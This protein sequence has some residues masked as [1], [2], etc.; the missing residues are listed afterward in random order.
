MW[1]PKCK[2]EY[3]EGI[4]VCADCGTE[5]VEEEQTEEVTICEISDEKTACELL[6]FLNYSGIKSGRKEEN[7][8]GIG[9]SIIVP[10]ADETAADKVVHGYLLAKEEEKETKEAHAADESDI[11]Q[12]D[13]M[14]EDADDTDESGSPEDGETVSEKENAD[15][16]EDDD[17]L[18][19]EEGEE[20]LLLADEVDEDTVD[21]LYASNKKEYVKKADLYRDTKFSGITFLIFGIIG[22]VYLVLSKTKVIPIHYN[23]VVFCIIAA[24]F[25]AFI[26]AG[27]VS[28]VK[29]KKIK[30]QIPEEEAKIKEI[31]EWLDENISKELVESW[32]D[33]SVSEMENDLVVTAH[34]RSELIKEYPDLEKEYIEMIAD[35][36]FEEHFLSEE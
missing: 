18:F 9:Y 32:L 8:D 11:S 5:L 27:I 34:I 4:T 14:A 3:R 2:I 33:K 20:N 1:C 36:Y 25:A 15:S 17:T 23:I 31:K 19:D 21:L 28:M 6:E 29:S 13:E 7:K 12:S 22:G 24:L 16:S 26:V 35:E 30:L 10:E